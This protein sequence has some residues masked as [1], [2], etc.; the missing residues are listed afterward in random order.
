MRWYSST[1][2]FAVILSLTAGSICGARSMA[3]AQYHA[4]APA[5]ARAQDEQE[6]LDAADERGES[7]TTSAPDDDDGIKIPPTRLYGGAW[8]GFAS[9]TDQNGQTDTP[10]G[11]S[12]LGGQFGIDVVGW[13]DL[14]SLG[15]ETR[16]GAAKSQVGDH[17]KLID[18]V[19]KPRLRLH[20]KGAPLEFYFTVPIG[21]TVPRFSDSGPGN[22]ANVGW[23]LGIGGGMNVFFSEHIGFNVEPLW[24]THHFNGSAGQGDL[25]IKQLALFINGVIAL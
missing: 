9:H 13:H 6:S 11:A 20:P 19:L 23:N 21:L 10:G 5:T 17:T 1:R 12:T 3:F 18:F 14:F 15:A 24:L 22:D 2:K 4:Q 8:L 7:A 16:I 25:T